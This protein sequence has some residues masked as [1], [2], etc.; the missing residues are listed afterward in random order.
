M[1]QCFDLL[2]CSY[3]LSLC[4]HYYNCYSSSYKTSLDK[5]LHRESY[6]NSGSIHNNAFNS[7]SSAME[8]KISILEE[9][10]C[11]DGYIRPTTVQPQNKSVGSNSSVGIIALKGKRHE[12]LHE[13]EL[14]ARNHDYPQQQQRQQQQQQQQQ[15]HH[16]LF[17]PEIVRPNL[18]M[19]G[20]ID[21]DCCYDNGDSSVDEKEGFK[22]GDENSNIVSIS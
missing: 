5:T 17:Q 9:I 20:D 1:I 4:Y 13:I 6:S 10:V 22:H 21:C 7:T 12:L 18:M 16:H 3:N 2:M 14:D 15:Q 8:K 11:S 19:N